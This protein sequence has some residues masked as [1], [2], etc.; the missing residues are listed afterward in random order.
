VTPELAPYY[1]TVEQVEYQNGQAFRSYPA[2]GDGRL[3]LV[4]DR[5]FAP[6]LRFSGWV[7]AAGD[8]S[9][10]DTDGLHV[11]VGHTS[12]ELNFACSL[13]RVDDLAVIKRE[14]DRAEYDILPPVGADGEADYDAEAYVASPFQVWRRY[15]FVVDWWDDRIRMRASSTLGAV[16]LTVAVLPR[17]REGDPVGV[18]ASGQVGFRFDNLETLYGGLVVSRP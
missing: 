3:R 16:D 9:K 11:H 5:F 18:P 12:N 13:S 2:E 17:D 1:G 6:P 4:S 8:E 7:M 14:A 15:S 10:N